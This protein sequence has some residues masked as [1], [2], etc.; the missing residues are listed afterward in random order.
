MDELRKKTTELEGTADE[1]KKREAL[2]KL[3]SFAKQIK[4]TKKPGVQKS[5][6]DGLEVKESAFDSDEEPSE[7]NEEELS[8]LDE[9]Y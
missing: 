9:D 6:E 5:T 7:I 1:Q 8:K 4:E 3:R 2:E